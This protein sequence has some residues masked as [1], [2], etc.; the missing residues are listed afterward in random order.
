MSTETEDLD[1]EEATKAYQAELE[2]KREKRQRQQ[3]VEAL[4][5]WVWVSEATAFVRKS[6]RK[7]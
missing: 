5:D 1:I 6:D 7:V 3:I 2:A 4:L